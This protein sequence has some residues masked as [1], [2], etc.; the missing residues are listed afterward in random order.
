MDLYIIIDYHTI[1][2]DNLKTINRLNPNRESLIRLRNI[3]VVGFDFILTTG[4]AKPDK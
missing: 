3:I 2:I 4:R 1:N